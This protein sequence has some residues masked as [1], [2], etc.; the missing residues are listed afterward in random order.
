LLRGLLCAGLL[1]GAAALHA[2]DNDGKKDAPPAARF[3]DAA[4]GW[5]DVSSFLDTAY[6]FVPI[7]APITEPAV[8]YGAAGALVFVDRNVPGAGQRF[9]RPNIAVAGGLATQ[10]GTQGLFGGHLGNWMDG[11]LRTL[12]GVADA[13]VN[14]DFFG[15]GG[16]RTPRGAGI[17]YT[18]AATGGVAGANYRLGDTQVWIGLRYALATTR[19]SL[20]AS[21]AGLPFIPDS[22]RD[23]RL[24]GLTPSITLD[25]R[26]NFF[27]PTSGSYL[28]LSVPVFREALG[29]DRNFEKVALTAMHFEPLARSLFLAVRGTA[30]TSSDG[31]P[32]YLR[33]FVWLRG[34]QAMEYQGDQ[35]AEVEAELRWQLHPRFS[36][37]GFGGAGVARGSALQPDRQKAVASGGGGVRYLLAREYG[38]WMG[39]DVGFGPGDPILYVTFGSAW[40][41]P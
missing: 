13:D 39:L 12:V 8:G 3:F 33:P 15:L 16:D 21:G 18:I 22:D 31:T 34:V 5:F 28:D 41:R 9:A 2:A 7:I 29:G 14:L 10:N 4:D 32:F 27:T 37:V 19:V 30:Q 23:L 38:L 26:D 36:L 40:V 35:T 25:T 20:T 1:L 24:A 17:G 6:G 11:R